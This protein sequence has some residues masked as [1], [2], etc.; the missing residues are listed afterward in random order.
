M[1]KSSSFSEIS[2]IYTR[3]F[4]INTCSSRRDDNRIRESDKQVLQTE[5]R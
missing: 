1:N 5:N 4:Y 2:I 3:F